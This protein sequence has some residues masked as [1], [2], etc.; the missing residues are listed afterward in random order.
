MTQSKI[1]HPQRANLKF[2]IA[3]IGAGVAGLAAAHKLRSDRPELEITIFEKS[4]GVGGRAATRRANSALFDHGAQ[5][6]KG[7]S[8]DVER[9]LRHTLP[10]DTLRNISLPV[11]TFDRNG[12]IVEGDPQQND[13]PKWTYSDGL[14]RL[15]KEL[16]RDLDVRTQTRIERIERRDHE[17]VLIDD[18]GREV[19]SANAI[20][21]TPPA[22]QTRSLIA[23]STLDHDTQPLL[24]ELGKA[25][26]RPC[27]TITLGF[28][29]ILRDRPFYA[30]VN[31]DK[32]HPLSWL[33]YE[34]TKPDRA[35]DGQHV[36]IAQMAPQWSRD[37][38]DD[39]LLTLTDRVTTMLRALLNEELPPPRWADRQGWRYA[40]PDDGSDFNALNNAI[41]GVFFAGDFTVGQGRVHRAIEEGRRVADRISAFMIAP[42]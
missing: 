22:P 31:T 17:Y 16:A 28:D 40:L 23:A 14:T 10:H 38:W 19:G 37:H 21:L 18:A 39:N 7:G 33:A 15:A 35:T 9:L 27:L 32:A 42:H 3:I 1:G 24:D 4:R 5:Y 29:P 34:H 8:P 26:Y 11:W 2:N 20:L 30:L 6:V 25:R 41:P 36:L 12:V 13:Q